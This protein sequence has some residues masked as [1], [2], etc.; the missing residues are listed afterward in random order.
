MSASPSGGIGSLESDLVHP[1]RRFGGVVDPELLWRGGVE[2]VDIPGRRLVQ[3]PLGERI[4]CQAVWIVELTNTGIV[5]DA[6]HS[7][8]RC[9]VIPGQ[10][11]DPHDGD[12]HVSP[13]VRR[14]H[15][16]LD[17]NCARNASAACG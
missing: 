3:E 2:Q 17:G 6:G 15:R 1:V 11:I 16:L 7:L 14:H 10:N 4:A 5:E 9:V 12:A 8:R 13:G